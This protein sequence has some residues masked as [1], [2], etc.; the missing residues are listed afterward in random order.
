MDLNQKART[1]SQ[2]VERAIAVLFAFDGE[3]AAMSLTDVADRVG[4]PVSTT[5]RIVGALVKGRLLDRGA[6][7]NYV[8]GPGIVDLAAR[9]LPELD[10]S[11]AAPHLHQLAAEIGI[12]ASLGMEVKGEAVTVYSAHPPI[13][14]CNQQI[15]E[16]RT[17]LDTSAMGQAIVAFHAGGRRPALRRGAAS[18]DVRRRG[19]SMATTASGVTAV[20]VPVFDGAGRVCASIGVQARSARLNREL[21]GRVV[22]VMRYTARALTP[23][24]ASANSGRTQMEQVPGVR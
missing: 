5:H 11:A 3:D 14:W 22:P 8:I 23:V 20:A 4:L 24:L 6:D 17:A 1:G 9:A 19:Y 2:S 12:T 15:P 7:G 16:P 10:H 21:I 13:R 18:S